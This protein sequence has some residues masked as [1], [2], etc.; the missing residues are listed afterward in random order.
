MFMIGALDNTPAFVVP[1]A[2]SHQETPKLG[3]AYGFHPHLSL[4]VWRCEI[5]EFKFPKAGQLPQHTRE[6]RGLTALAFYKQF[7]K[8]KVFL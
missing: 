3:E 6:H 8:P 7:D 5:M 4:L 1:E 2:F